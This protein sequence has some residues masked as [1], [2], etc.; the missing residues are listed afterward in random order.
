MLKKLFVTAAAAAAVSVP[1]A[2]VAWADQP[3][4][5]ADNG[6]GNKAGGV[7]QDAGDALASLGAGDGSRV[8]PGSVFSVSAKKDGNTPDAYGKDLTDFWSVFGP[9]NGEPAYVLDTTPPGKATKVFTPGCNNGNV[10]SAT[11]QP[12]DG[13]R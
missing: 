12:A 8:T 9:L 11:P 6:N 3:A 7:P 1:L 13:C 2:G 4:D 5:A 10:L